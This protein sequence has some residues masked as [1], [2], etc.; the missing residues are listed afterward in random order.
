MVILQMQM[1]QQQA[2][3]Q[4]QETP[5]SDQAGAAPPQEGEVAGG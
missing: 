2:D 1:M 5:P 3:H 4:G